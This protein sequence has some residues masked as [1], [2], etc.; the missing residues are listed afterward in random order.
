M[1]QHP[2]RAPALTAT[3]RTI[4]WLLRFD[5]RASAT[6]IASSTRLGCVTPAPGLR[7]GDDLRGS[8]RQMTAV[9]TV[10]LTT[11]T[12]GDAR[13]TAG[14]RGVTETG[15]QRGVQPDRGAGN[16]AASR[17]CCKGLDPASHD[18]RTGAR[19]VDPRGEDP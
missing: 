1:S 14:E 9:N 5:I 8:R 19:S 7:K 12:T 10:L 15:R 3:T 11:A 18:P 2:P 4:P 16:E 13:H 6:V 17:T